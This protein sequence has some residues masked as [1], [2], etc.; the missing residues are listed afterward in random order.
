M[1]HE[2]L[3]VYIHSSTECEMS[4]DQWNNAL[5]QTLEAMY[6]A[7][8]MCIYTNWW[9]IYGCVYRTEN[10]Y[11]QTAI[12]GMLLWFSGVLILIEYV[13]AHSF[14]HLWIPDHIS[15]GVRY[16][17]ETKNNID[18]HS[19]TL[20]TIHTAACNHIISCAIYS[21]G[22]YVSM[23]V[24]YIILNKQVYQMYDLTSSLSESM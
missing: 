23:L 1:S 9:F 6:V 5:I 17:V 7:E 20:Y 21:H 19:P 13:D 22:A 3:R 15:P 18:F 8:R 11:A 12:A 2:K 10:T 16:R 24:L 4:Q 14:G